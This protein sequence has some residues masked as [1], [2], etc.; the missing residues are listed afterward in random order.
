MRIKKTEVCQKKLMHFSFNTVAW[1]HQCTMK[2]HSW[3]IFQILTR[4]V[5]QKQVSIRLTL[6]NVFTSKKWLTEKKKSV[7]TK[8]RTGLAMPHHEVVFTHITRSTQ[9]TNTV[10]ICGKWSPKCYATRLSREISTSRKKVQVK[11]E[12]P[13]RSPEK[14]C[15]YKR[16]QAHPGRKSFV[17][18]GIQSET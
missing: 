11:V 6:I 3:H 12:S 7:K 10:N 2:H 8:K 15:G 14:N 9:R 17:K 1:I 4:F 5:H 13:R 18:R 16:G